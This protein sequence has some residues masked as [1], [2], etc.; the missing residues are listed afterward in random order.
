MNTPYTKNTYSIGLI[1]LFQVQSLI[2]IDIYFLFH[3][4]EIY[5]LDS[6]DPNCKS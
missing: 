3:Y 4:D 6:R 2:G 5:V 1:Q